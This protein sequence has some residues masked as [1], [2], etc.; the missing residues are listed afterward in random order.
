MYLKSYVQKRNYQKMREDS[1]L[2][3]TV[4]LV[5]LIL[6]IKLLAHPLLQQAHRAINMN[7]EITSIKRLGM[8]FPFSSA[9]ISFS[10]LTKSSHKYMSISLLLSV[11]IC[12]WLSAALQ[13]RWQQSARLCKNTAGRRVSVVLSE[14]KASSAFQGSAEGMM[15]TH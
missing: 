12:L 3:V 15:F 9:S 2:I 1:D 10:Q 5:F 6:V 4:I 13:T 14:Q 11:C 8:C 7:I